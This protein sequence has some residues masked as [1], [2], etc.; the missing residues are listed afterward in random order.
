MNSSIAARSY[1]FAPASRPE[2]FDKALGAGADAVIIDLEDAVAPGEKT[3]ARAALAAWLTPAHK[4]LV[5][6]NAHGTAWFEDDLALCRHA[7]IS[8]IVVPKSEHAT[9]LAH[10]YAV[11]KKALYPIIESAR[12]VDQLRELA[13]AD[14]VRCLVFGTIDFKLDLGIDGDR[15]ELLYFRSQIVLASRLAG[16]CAPVD[17]VTTAI[18]DSA[19][20]SADTLYAQRIGFGA[21]LCIHPKQV[22]PVNAAFAPSMAQLAWAHRVLAV[23]RNAGRG[24]VALD[25]KMIDLPV[26]LKAE[27]VV[28]DAARRT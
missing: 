14:A 1:L 19:Q 18:D 8:G 26:I 17:G 10:V 7:G 3:A 21:K 4:V 24:A 27:Q 5:R 12:G 28:Q 13:G 2:R 25:G 9:D 6:I 23:A 20:I 22:A 15:D 11:T 16:L